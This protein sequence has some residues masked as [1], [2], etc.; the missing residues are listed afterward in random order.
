MQALLLELLIDLE[1]IG[2]DHEDLFDSEVRERIGEAVMQGF[3]RAI[4]DYSVRTDLGMFKPEADAAVRQLLIRYIA[5]ANALAADKQIMRFHD[6]LAAFQDS[7]VR[8]PNGNDYDEFF[9]H[10]P[11]EYYNDDGTVQ[12][13]RVR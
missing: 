1:R 3:V 4:P 13:D 7:D 2:N 11:P 8:T 5:A 9:G 10:T 6:R 12:W